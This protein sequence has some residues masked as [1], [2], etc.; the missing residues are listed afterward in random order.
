MKQQRSWYAIAAVLVLL[1]ITSVGIVRAVSQLGAQAHPSK[2]GTSVAKTTPTIAVSPTPAV[3]ALTLRGTQIL[4]A[5]GNIVTLIGASRSSLEYLCAGDGHFALS[6]FQ[7]MRAWGM[8][9]VRIPLSSEFW[10]NAG[11]DCPTYRQTVTNAVFNAESAGM[12]VILDL[13]WNAPFD[14][15]H[16]RQFGGVQ[17]SMPDSGKDVAFWED[18]ATI[19]H[20]DQKV[21]FDLFGEPHDVPWQTWLGGGPVSFGCYIING[22]GNST[23]EPGTYQ[24]IGMRDLA[25]KVH[26]IAPKNIVIVSGLD[27]GYN[28]A[29]VDQGYAI[30]GGNIL[31]G[32]HPFNYSSK[33]PALWPHDFGTVAAHLPVI[34]TEFGSYDC[35]TSYTSAAI[36]YFTAHHMSW[37][38]WSWNLSGCSGPALITDWNGTPNA[39]YGAFIQQQMLAA[40][41]N[42]G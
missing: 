38:A 1:A 20:T 14:T 15:T 19:Y 9:V 4:D 24:A 29:G 2:T 22:T 10:A 30:S 28:L 12:Y 21:L 13:Q 18:L 37:L 36:S 35:A 42:N 40:A 26:D 17:C 27:W 25:G 11:G 41:K 39:P 32:T 23:L 3:P 34:A 31:Y 7:A 8:N 6:D 5:H 33:R 16:D